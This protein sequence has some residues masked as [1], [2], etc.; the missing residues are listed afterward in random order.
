MKKLIKTIL[1]VTVTML[2]AVSFF[3]CSDESNN[4]GLWTD[5][6]YSEDSEI[7]KGEKRIEIEIVID[8]SSVILT[9]NTDKETLGEALFEYGLIN[10]ASFFDTLN[11]IKA[12][13]SKDQAY[14]GFYKNN[15]LMAKG[16]GDEKINGGESYSFVYTK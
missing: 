11:G 5:A 9:V 10:D 7:G 4:E 14:W 15:E 12:D 16:V 8:G 1:T 3:S 2:V 13:W 6:V